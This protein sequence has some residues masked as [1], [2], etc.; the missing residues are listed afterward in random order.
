MAHEYVRSKCSESRYTYE[1]NLKNPLRAD[2]FSG[3]RLSLPVSAPSAQRI[4]G[5]FTLASGGNS[6]AIA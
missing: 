2:R 6:I 1:E 3:Q 4:A 5:A